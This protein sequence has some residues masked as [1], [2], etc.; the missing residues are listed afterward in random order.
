MLHTAIGCEI[1][2]VISEDAYVADVFIENHR[3]IKDGK[4]T[5]PKADNGNY[6][7]ADVSKQKRWSRTVFIVRMFADYKDIFQTMIYI[8]ELLHVLG[9]DHDTVPSGI[10]NAVIDK[11][12]DQLSNELIADLHNSYCQA[13]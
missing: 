1:F 8:H 11:N 5:L 4:N 13:Q 12:H 7:L 6:R 9:V 10:M 2:M 3:N